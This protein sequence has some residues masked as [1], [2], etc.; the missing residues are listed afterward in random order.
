V[1]MGEIGVL[2]DTWVDG[3]VPMG[4]VVTENREE[5]VCL[6]YAE[7]A[8]AGDHVVVHMGFVTDV[9]DPAQADDARALRA[10]AGRKDP[11]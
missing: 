3:G 11:T 1:C 7:G 6:L 9:L 2:A 4:R 8:D 10:R 5:E